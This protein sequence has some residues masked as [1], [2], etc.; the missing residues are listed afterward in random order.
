MEDETLYSLPSMPLARHRFLLKLGTRCPD[1]N[2][3]K[4]ALQKALL[5]HGALSTHFL[6]L[7]FPFPACPPSPFPRHGATL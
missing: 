2:E 7:V 3:H 5:E 6:S 1:A 4:A